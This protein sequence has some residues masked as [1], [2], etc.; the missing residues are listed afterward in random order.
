MLLGGEAVTEIAAG[1]ADPVVYK[2]SGKG[3]SLTQGCALGPELAEPP[4]G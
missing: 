2:L 1:N 3:G 4:S